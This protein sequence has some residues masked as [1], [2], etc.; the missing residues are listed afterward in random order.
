MSQILRDSMIGLDFETYSA[1]SLPDYGLDRYVNDPHFQV[2]IASVAH[3]H[4]LNAAWPVELDWI[5]DGDQTEELYRLI[6]GNK[7][8]AHNAGF[9][10][11]VL[12]RIG[13]VLPADRFIDS[14]VAARAL[15]AGGKLEAAAPQLLGTDK[16]EEGRDLIRLFCIP[17]KERVEDGALDFDQDLAVQHAD[18]WKLFKEYC[19]VDAEL[20]LQLALYGID[21]GVVTQRELDHNAITMEMNTTGWHVDIDSV[22]EMQ[23]RYQENQLVALAEF[24]EEY[25][26]HAGTPD[27]LNLNSL[28]Q[29]KEWCAERGIKANSFDEKNVEKLKA[30]IL[31]RLDGA[32]NGTKPLDHTKYTQYCEV[33]RLLETKQVLGGSSLKKLQVILDTTGSDS[34]LRDQYLHCGAGQTWRTT[35]KGVQMQNLK[36]IG[37]PADMRSLFD[38]D[39]EWTNDDLATNLRQ[40]FTA[41]H[42]QGVLIVGD[43][44]SVE[45]R[46]LAW[47]A[48]AHW[49]LDAFRKGKD[50]YKVQAQHIYGTLY[51]QVTKAQRQTGKVGELSC[52][53][54]A[55][56]GAVQSFASGMGV[57][58]TEAEATDIVRNWRDLNVEIVQFWEALDRLLRNVVEH[59][60]MTASAPAGKDCLVSVAK[61]IT[62]RSLIK[63]HPDAQSIEVLLKDG[64]NQVLVRRFFHGCYM[65]G[66]SI[67]YYKPSQLKTGDLW[68]NHFTDPKT[69]QVRFYSVYGGK[70]AGI[71]TQSLCREIFFAVLK[72]VSDLCQQVPNVRLVG[73]FHDEIVVEWEPGDY[74][75]ADTKHAMGQLMSNALIVSGFP[76]DAEVKHDYRYTK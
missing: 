64:R 41:S 13:I 26:E 53:Y 70:L 46:G 19:S 48:N 24:R 20:G 59:G 44:S 8:V 66:N 22:K 50:L 37:T 28:K 23:R 71:L 14:A 34:R 7:I 67:G 54:Q 31:K 69:K 29:L 9:E 18:K 16:M 21:R 75:L 39:S 51:D 6:G 52:G 5:L 4:S 61:A 32:D 17:S 65:R 35:G 38:D 36:R 33:L 68:K 57:E 11:A 3:T 2:L 25:D 27:E 60:D 30:R 42:P 74:G 45:S 73:Q 43:F 40:V 10:R 55:G 49:K 1:T 62:P 12:H 76:L 72:E 58:L 15:G 63:Q 56:P 47:L